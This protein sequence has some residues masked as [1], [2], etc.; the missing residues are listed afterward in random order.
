MMDT[1]Q[2]LMVLIAEVWEVN[3]Y[4]EHYMAELDYHTNGL[5]LVV[6]DKDEES[7]TSKEVQTVDQTS[8]LAMIEFL[9]SVV[10]EG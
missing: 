9:Q 2:E 5:K 10:K 1:R 8:V 3:E 4:K 6:Y 7:I